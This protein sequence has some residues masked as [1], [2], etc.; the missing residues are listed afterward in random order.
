MRRSITCLP[1][2][3]LAAIVLAGAPALAA[4]EEAVTWRLF[5]AD[6]ATPTVTVLDIGSEERWQ[7]ALKGPS[8]LYPTPSGSA[9]VAVQSDHDAVDFLKSGILRESHGDH[10]DLEVGPPATIEGTL[11][12]P[13]PFHVVM[14]GDE[15]AINFDRGG[16]VTILEEGDILAGDLAGTAF[17]Q[18]RAHHGFAVSVGDDV[19]VSSVASDAPT[20]GDAA[21][22]RVG[23]RA[24]SQSGEPLT[25]TAT[26][27]DLHGE[28]FS[29]NYLVAGCKEGVIAIDTSQSPPT[30]KMLAYPETFPDA[31]TGTLLGARAMQA[32]LGNYGNQAVV[33]IDPAADEPFTL[34]ELPFRRVDFVLDPAHPKYGYVLTEDG[35]LHRL[36]LLAGAIEA[37]APVT[38]PYSMDG[39]WRDPRPRL[40]MAGETIVVTDPLKSLV[41]LVD[42]GT[43]EETG[44]IAVEGLPY[45][46]IAV[47]GAGLT[48]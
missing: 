4:D 34:V 24:Y 33:V 25:P 29:G 21:P 32:F 12:G 11:E 15:A 3:A 42:T 23:I 46:V 13:R 41:R 47:G 26:C 43:L 37:S 17:E 10:A 22:P 1:S 7:F 36:D 5:V 9:V 16:Y 19:V 45:N 40:A 28:A 20:E 6:Q 8:R 48:H 38:E 35:S 30:F 18:N 14:H 2:L 44:S 27:T 31:H 39:H